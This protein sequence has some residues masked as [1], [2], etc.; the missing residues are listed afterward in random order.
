M[1]ERTILSW[2]ITNWLTILLMVGI[3]FTVVAAVVSMGRQYWGGGST[4]TA[5][6]GASNG[7]TSLPASG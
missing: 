3:G 2:N 1:A 4:G 6:A 7:G 5:N